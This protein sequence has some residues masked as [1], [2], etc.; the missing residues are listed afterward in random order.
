M[1]LTLDIGRR[2]DMTAVAQVRL[3]LDGTMKMIQSGTFDLNNPTD[4]RRLAT[5]FGIL[6]NRPDLEKVLTMMKRGG[7]RVI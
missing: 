5:E 4:L 7:L 3:N 1:I 2:D 6:D